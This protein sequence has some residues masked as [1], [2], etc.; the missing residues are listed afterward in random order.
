[1]IMNSQY[2]KEILLLE[3]RIEMLRKND[4]FIKELYCSSD[5]YTYI[6]VRLNLKAEYDDVEDEMK[7]IE[8]LQGI[9]IQYDKCKNDIVKNTSFK[10]WTDIH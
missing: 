4:T 8:Q 2:A 7:F 10:T 9:Y 5:L 1:M 3:R 6:R